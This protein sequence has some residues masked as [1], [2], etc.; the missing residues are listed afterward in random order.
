MRKSGRTC[1]H[2][3][4]LLLCA[5]QDAPLHGC[6]KLLEDH[7]CIALL[8][9]V[10]W[11]TMCRLDTVEEDSRPASVSTAHTGPGIAAFEM[12][13]RTILHF[14]FVLP[15]GSGSQ[16]S[17][18]HIHAAGALESGSLPAGNGVHHQ[19]VARHPGRL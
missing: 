18:R 6:A 15:A 4:L 2:T 17:E 7:A 14:R 1:L 9:H 3:A 11:P 13:L 16:T 19:P 10:S 12:V 5:R 8:H